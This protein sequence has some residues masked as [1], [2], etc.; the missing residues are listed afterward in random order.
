[1]TTVRVIVVALVFG[2]SAQAQTLTAMYIGGA[3]EDSCRDVAFDSAGNFY[4]TGGTESPDFVTTDGTTVNPG[5][6]GAGSGPH[7]AW[8]A[9]FSPSG[10]LLWA[11]VIGG[12]GYDRAYA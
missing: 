6:N 10:R 12:N 11:T 2:A 3:A 5:A 4:A 9:K 8:V 1:M 7:D